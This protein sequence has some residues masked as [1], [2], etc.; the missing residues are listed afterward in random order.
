MV[1]IVDGHDRLIYFAVHFTNMSHVERD[2]DVN[3]STLKFVSYLIN[4]MM[5]AYT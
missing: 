2:K 4:L 5:L 3:C 1:P